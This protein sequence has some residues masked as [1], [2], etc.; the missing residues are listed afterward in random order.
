L[1]ADEHVDDPVA[2]EHGLHRDA[3]RASGAGLGDRADRDRADP[4]RVR[5]QRRDRRVCLGGRDDRDELALVREVERISIRASGGGAYD[6][7]ATKAASTLGVPPAR[8]STPS[9]SFMTRR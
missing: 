5:R 3:A 9:P 8:I 2:A 4:E 7:R 6:S 1:L